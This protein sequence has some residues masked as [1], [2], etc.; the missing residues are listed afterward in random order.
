VACAVVILVAG[1]IAFVQ[2]SVHQVHVRFKNGERI[3]YSSGEASKAAQ[4]QEAVLLALDHLDYH[5]TDAAKPTV[6]LATLEPAQLTAI[7]GSEP[8]VVRLGDGTLKKA[9]DD[10]G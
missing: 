6:V 4:F 1:Y 7:Q 10:D 5:D 9:G 8:D 2:P 3:V